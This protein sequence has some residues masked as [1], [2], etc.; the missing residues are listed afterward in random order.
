MIL[1]LIP[2][3]STSSVKM[4]APGVSDISGARRMVSTLCS[5]ASSV[6]KVATK[7]TNNK[8]SPA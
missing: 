6:Q 1:A 4:S 8:T 7:Q 5:G 2:L 3:Q